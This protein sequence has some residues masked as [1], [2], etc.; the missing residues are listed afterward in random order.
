MHSYNRFSYWFPFSNP[1][2]FIH[3]S[4]F[5]LCILCSLSQFVPFLPTP[6]AVMHFQVQ[7]WLLWSGRLG[8]ICLLSMSLDLI[9]ESQTH[10]ECRKDLHECFFHLRHDK[11]IMCHTYL[12]SKG[13]EL[14]QC[15][16][17]ESD[18]EPSW[19]PLRHQLCALL[20]WFLYCQLTWLVF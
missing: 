8:W 18:T 1:L 20:P 10:I 3:K 2:L 9:D 4:D 11:S 15:Q 16:C 5:N 14:K 12:Y 13:S 6:T 17:I 19:W 7:C